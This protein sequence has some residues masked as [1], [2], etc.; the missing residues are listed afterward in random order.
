MKY[1][2]KIACVLLTVVTVLT[3]CSIG[4]REIV[5]D[6]N[7]SSGHT[8]LVIDKK[9]CNITEAKLYLANYKNLYGDVYGVNLY[10]T[11]DASKVEKYVKDVTVD[12]LARVYCM[13]AIAGEKKIAL[14]EQRKKGSFRCRKGIL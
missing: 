4:G 9:K 14:T 12:E 7:S 2:K 6:I 8:L 1:F 11:K 3:G 10:K 13:V 5:M